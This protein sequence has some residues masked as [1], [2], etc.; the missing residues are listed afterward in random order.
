MI[1][2]KLGAT[3]IL[4]V[5]VFI[6]AAAFNLWLFKRLL[7]ALEIGKRKIMNIFNENIVMKLLLKSFAILIF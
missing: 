7:I 6:T 3:L 4:W 1:P 2:S 5:N